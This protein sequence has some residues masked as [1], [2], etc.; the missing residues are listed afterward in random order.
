MVATSTLKPKSNECTCDVAEWRN[1][2]TSFEKEPD[3]WEP[4]WAETQRNSEATKDRSCL[5]L[6]K[7]LESCLSRAKRSTL[8]CATVLVPEQLTRRIAGQMLRLAS[9]EPCGLRGCVLD[10]V[11]EMDKGCK[12]LERLVYDASVVPTFELTLVF[13]QDAAVWPSLRDL[14]FMGT[15]FAPSFRRALKLSRGFRLVKKK[16]YSSSGGTVIEEC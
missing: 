5:W 9:C 7:M 16:L 6:A 13:K 8:H 2:Q 12:R 14:L 1:D 4:W 15:C 3:F 11:L 10:V